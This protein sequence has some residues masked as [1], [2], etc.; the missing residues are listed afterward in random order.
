M[1]CLNADFILRF[2]TENVYTYSSNRLR[3]VSWGEV[4]REII[5]PHIRHDEHYFGLLQLPEHQ[6]EMARSIL[7]VTDDIMV[8]IQ[9]TMSE[10]P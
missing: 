8:M 1:D 6:E 7:K 2:P 10:W 4:C 5:F 9:P 3:A